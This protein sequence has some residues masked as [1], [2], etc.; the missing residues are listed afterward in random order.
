MHINTYIYIYELYMSMH[1]FVC[2]CV[3]STT[4]R[5]ISYSKPTQIKRQIYV[6]KEQD[7]DNSST[8]SK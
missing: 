3:Y 8:S 4:V 6:Y 1:V 5:H 2:V 7:R